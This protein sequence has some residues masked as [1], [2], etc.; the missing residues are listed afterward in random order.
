MVVDDGLVVEDVERN[1]GWPERR[2]ASG[3][4]GGGG[5]S[6]GTP[7][8]AHDRAVRDPNAQIRR[9]QRRC[10]T[11]RQRLLLVSRE[12]WATREADEVVGDGPS[13]EGAPGDVATHPPRTA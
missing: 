8:T 6:A 12:A 10:S 13:S 1:E 11:T 2:E 9:G 4:R 3:Q 5:E 7:E